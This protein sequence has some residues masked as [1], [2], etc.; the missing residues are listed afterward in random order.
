MMGGMIW[1]PLEATDSMA[2]D[3]SLLMPWFFISGIVKAPVVA[4]FAAALPLTDPMATL[5]TTAVWVMPD[6]T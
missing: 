3:V 6:L 1:P 2:A 4:A 5:V